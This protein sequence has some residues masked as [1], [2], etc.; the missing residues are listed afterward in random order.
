MEGEESGA[1][2]TDKRCL[3][4]TMDDGKGEVSPIDENEEWAKVR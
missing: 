1:V 4:V 3:G 2:D